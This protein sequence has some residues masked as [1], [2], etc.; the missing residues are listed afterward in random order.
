MKVVAT[1]I[2]DQDK[3]YLEDVAVALDRP[4]SWVLRKMIEYAIEQH[5]KG[6]LN[7]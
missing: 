6:E 2:S 1:R 5:K 3:I 4:L 7:L